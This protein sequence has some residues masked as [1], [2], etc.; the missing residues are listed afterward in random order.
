MGYGSGPLSKLSYAS[1]VCA[2][3]SMLLVRQQDAVG[4][5][6]AHG[7][8]VEFLPP[9]SSAAHVSAIAEL[10][11]AVRPEGGTDLGAVAHAVAEKARRRALILIFS[12]LFESGVD[13]DQGAKDAAGSARP[14]EGRG[15]RGHRRRRRAEPEHRTGPRFRT[16]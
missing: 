12:D 5:C 15:A 16:A 11:A 1:T 14:G 2:A 13:L 10:L 7:K 6:L 4:L 8:E 3:L 9:H